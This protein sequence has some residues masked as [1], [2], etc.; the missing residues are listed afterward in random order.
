ML[1]KINLGPR[2]FGFR[3]FP[4]LLEFSPYRGNFSPFVGILWEF[5]LSRGNFSPS[6]EFWPR[7]DGH[8]SVFIYIAINMEFPWEKFYILWMY[9]SLKLT[10]LTRSLRVTKYI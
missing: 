10:S 2:S 5:S 7:T 1:E 9:F 8:H 4:L 6:Q 3:L